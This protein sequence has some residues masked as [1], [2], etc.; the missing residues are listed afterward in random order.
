MRGRP[1][2]DDRGD[3]GDLALMNLVAKIQA[4]WQ[5]LG[6]VQRALLIAISVAF[7]LV[8]LLLLNW[9]SQP[10]MRVL[11]SDLSPEDA[12]KITEK[13][14]EKDIAYE[15]RGAGT[16][17]YVPREHVS[18]LR[19]DMARE[20]L[21]TG[22][23]LGNS[24][25]DKGKI[26]DS[27]IIQDLKRK[28]GIEEELAKSVQMIEGVVYARVHIVTAE[29]TL[30]TSDAGNTSASVVL[31]MQPGYRMSNLNI[32]A[33]THLVSSGVEGLDTENV[34][35]VDSQ[36]NLLSSGSDAGMATGA[37]TVQ[38]YRERVEQSLSSEVEELLTAALGAGRA[39]VKVSAVI[40]MNSVSTIT[41]EY[42][43]TGKVTKKEEITTGAEPVSSGQAGG[44][45]A[46][47]GMKKDETIMTEYEVGRI[48]KQE[49]V[50]PGT[51]KSLSVAAMVDLSV[52][53]ANGTAGAQAATIVPLSD[54]EEIIMKSLGLKDTSNVKVINVKFNRSS[55]VPPAEEAGGGLSQYIGIAR[56]ASMGT[57]AV[58]AVLFVKILGG[59]KTQKRKKTKKK[60]F[61]K[62]AGGEQAS[63]PESETAGLLEGETGQNDKVTMQRQI[64]EALR[65]DPARVKQLFASW[66]EQTE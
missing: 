56:Q 58:C 57:M 42:D 39:K 11:Y 50:L 4:V 13:I 40:D 49:T 26:G 43:P 1:G 8:G 6:V 63:L 21:P 22:G 53:D 29:R 41:E 60:K 37:E 24:W 59:S 14:R 20:G 45:G 52:E 9:A 15:L 28:R 55:V 34:T 19:L 62:E 61:K 3:N 31:R 32:A 36:G 5:R 12:S 64:A 48:V 27:P 46:A 2:A 33:I 10:D 47:T 17:I 51:V 66:V 44:A 25:L 30:F 54:V 35:V 16:T 38:D 65:N 18:E 7:V 23:Q